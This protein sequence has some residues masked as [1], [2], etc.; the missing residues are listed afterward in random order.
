[1]KKQTDPLASTKARMDKVLRKPRKKPCTCKNTE[2]VDVMISDPDIVKLIH[3]GIFYVGLSERG[4]DALKAA[5]ADPNFIAD[6]KKVGKAK[7]KK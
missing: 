1:M 4:Q 2:V 6:L 7:A 5:L 3:M